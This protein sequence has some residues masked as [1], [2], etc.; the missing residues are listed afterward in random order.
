MCLSMK[1]EVYKDYLVNVFNYYDNKNLLT[2]A[3]FKLSQI[4]YQP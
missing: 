2:T 1:E 4:T 3:D